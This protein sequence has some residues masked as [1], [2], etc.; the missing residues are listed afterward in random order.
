MNESNN[1]PVIVGIFIF[2]GLAILAA[3]IF[4][5]GG[6]KKTFTKSFAISAIF[7]DVGGLQSGGNI[8]FSGVKVGTV[9]KISF[10]GDAQVQVTMSIENDAKSHIHK[11]SKAKISSDGL[12]G[13]KIIIIYGGAPSEP[14]VV[15]NDFLEVENVFSTDD[16]LATLQVNN[17]NLEAI[18]TDFKSISKKIDSGQGT[19][20]TLL[21]DPTIAINLNKSAAD[22]QLTLS[23]LKLVSEK[24]K[25]VMADLGEFSSKLNK[26][27]SSVNEL[28]EDT[29]IYRNINKAMADL[30]KST[31]SLNQFTSNLENTGAKLNQ[32][33]NAIG[34]LLND[35]E[36]ATSIQTTL[37]NLETSSEKLDENLKA[38]QH[39][40]LFRRYFRKKAK[41][42][43]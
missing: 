8:W 21:N 15:E 9:K 35:P 11:D 26:P 7:N 5:L 13:N 24:S 39:N 22:L 18:T 3:T 30:K 16:M 1:K 23:N 14:H 17:K 12:I 10:H 42:K 40:F 27:G 32:K 31:Y 6:Q 20:G 29:L 2:I 34:V 19:L 4:T 33:D 41:L 43:D 28:L 37:Q 38:L 25:L 36:S